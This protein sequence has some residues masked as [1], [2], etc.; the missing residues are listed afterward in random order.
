MHPSIGPGPEQHHEYPQKFADLTEN[1]LF[2]DIWK[3]PQLSPRERSL[4]TVAAL[5]PL[6][7]PEQH[8]AL[9]A[10]VRAGLTAAWHR[11]EGDAGFVQ[12][13]HG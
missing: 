9:N 11:F 10:E 7:R 2:D 6:N 8:N 13:D 3:R 12:R 1:L 4:I 5:I